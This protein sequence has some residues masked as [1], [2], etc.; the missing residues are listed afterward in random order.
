MPSNPDRFPRSRRTAAAHRAVQ[1]VFLLGMLWV[2]LR[3][4][5]YAAWVMG[6]SQDFVARPPAVE[7]FLPISALLALKRLLL[8][9]AWDA[10][11][12]A[13]LTILLCALT[14]AL[15][16]RKGFCGYV[17]PV[18]TVSFWLFQLGRRWGVTLSPPRRLSVALAIPKYLLL[19]FFLRLVLPGG[20]GLAQ[21][22]EFLCSPYNMVAD[23]KM[24]LFF[25][26]PSSTVAVVLGLLVLAGV[27]LPSFWCRFL[28]PYGALLG[29]LSWM[30]PVAVR[31]NT[32]TCTSCRACSRACPQGIAVDRMTHVVSPECNGC[33]E[34]VGACPRTDCLAM[35]VGAGGRRLPWWFS[36]AGVA[37]M[38]IGAW[39]LA[40]ITGHW[41]SDIPPEMARM[42]HRGIEHLSHY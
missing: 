14:S 7:G 6:L 11:H 29:L 41:V 39:I 40:A 23:T 24:L 17:C 2:G 38:F 21:I 10:V 27:F 30:S 5:L 31:R 42:L 19:A 37:A 22:D 1:I 15:L 16:L 9:G 33:Q 8:T 36:G 13:G 34:C 25:A 4:A 20:M 28:C 26:P 3:F 35:S 12:P 32:A 18:G